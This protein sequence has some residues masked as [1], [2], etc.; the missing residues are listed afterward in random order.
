MKN[1]N[2]VPLSNDVVTSRMAEMSCDIVNQVV[3]AIKE[4]PVRIS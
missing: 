2:Q 3:T 1:I 4:S